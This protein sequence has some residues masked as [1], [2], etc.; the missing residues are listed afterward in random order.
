MGKAIIISVKPEFVSKILDGSKTIELRK[1]KPNINDD[2]IILL[3]STLPVKAIV[4]ICRFERIIEAAPE[5][6]WTHYSHLV[7]IDKDR[8]IEY[9]KNTETAIGIVLKDINKLDRSITL[10]SLRK[11]MPTFTPPQTFKYFNKKQFLS[12]YKSLAF[13]FNG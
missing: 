13:A 8:F 5:E 4:G 12:H 6:I 11:K 3:Y 7:G 2:D 1:A 10:D 9:Y